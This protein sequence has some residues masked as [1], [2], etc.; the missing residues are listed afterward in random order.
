MS[1]FAEMML[2]NNPQISVTDRNIYFYVHESGG[3]AAVMCVGRLGRSNLG[4]CGFYVG[5]Q[6]SST[7]REA[8]SAHGHHTCSLS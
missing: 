8:I 4:S 3:L 1:A 6:E 5:G 7:F 2:H